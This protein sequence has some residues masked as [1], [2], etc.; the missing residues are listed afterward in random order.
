MLQHTLYLRGLSCNSFPP[1]VS[2]LQSACMYHPQ[3]QMVSLKL[4]TKFCGHEDTFIFK[5]WEGGSKNPP[6]QPLTSV[7]C[8]E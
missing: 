1:A 3:T 2:A 8:G 4:P 6:P 5:Y 7:S